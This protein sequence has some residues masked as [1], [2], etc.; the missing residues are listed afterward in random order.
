MAVNGYSSGISDNG[1]NDE[2]W[3]RKPFGVA[4]LGK[5]NCHSFMA[6]VRLIFGCSE[7]AVPPGKIEAVVA[8]RFA[9]NHGM[10]YRCISGVTTKSLSTRSTAMEIWILLWLNM[11]VALRV[12]SKMDSAIP[13][14]VAYASCDS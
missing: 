8:V 7:K 2:P 12:T 3:K 11:A 10:M 6:L 1:Q 4:K 9:D 14:V 5:A 13:D